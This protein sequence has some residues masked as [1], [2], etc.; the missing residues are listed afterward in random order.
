MDSRQMVRGW[1]WVDGEGQ[2]EAFVL[3]CFL[4]SIRKSYLTKGLRVW[5]R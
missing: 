2:G 3:E 4:V 1:G 5:V